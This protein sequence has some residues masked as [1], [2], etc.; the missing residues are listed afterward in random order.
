MTPFLWNH[1]V[2]LAVKMKVGYGFWTF[3][4]QNENRSIFLIIGLQQG[5]V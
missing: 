4:I 3:V 1:V 2:N 5:V